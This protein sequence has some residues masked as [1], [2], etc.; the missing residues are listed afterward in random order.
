MRIHIELQAHLNGHVYLLKFMKVKHLQSIERS[1]FA[2]VVCRAL[3]SI[4]FQT[5]M[6]EGTLG[7]SINAPLDALQGFIDDN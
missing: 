3:I 6:V 4:R 1:P 2:S 5:R 7:I